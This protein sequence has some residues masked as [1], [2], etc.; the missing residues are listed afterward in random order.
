MSD[1]ENL[2]YTVGWIS[3]LDTELLA[4][5]SVLK[6]RHNKVEPLS[7][8]DDNTYE[9]GEIGGHYVVIAVLPDG[10]HGTVPAANVARNMLHSFPNVRIGLMVGIA[11]GAP[12]KE[13]DIRLGDVVVS[14]P[15]SS[16]DNW[17]AI[18]GVFQYDFGKNIQGKDFQ[19]TRVLNQP[20]IVLRTAVNALKTDY[21]EKGHQIRDIVDEIVDSN[22]R[23]RGKYGPP[24]PRT[25]RLY[26]ST[27]EHVEIENNQNPCQGCDDEY[28]VPRTPLERNERRDDPMIHYGIIASADQLMK[29]ALDRDKLAKNKG[30]L[31]FEMEAAGLMDHFPCLVIRGICDYSDSHK[32][33]AWQGYAAMA[34]ALY[35]RDLLGKIHPAR[36]EQ[37][38]R[39]VD[40]V[41]ELN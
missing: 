12:T 30:V 6:Y 21:E 34:A 27:F 41:G 31:C 36:V 32:N 33:K 15:Q 10:T 20:P 40:V 9:F 7:K 18:G 23:L 11:G 37:E 35:A 29:N 17:G 19:F 14:S 4:A 25:D 22:K 5:K 28:L 39:I 3:A 1:P 8:H 13:H 38:T 24:D 16:P 2:K 26:Q